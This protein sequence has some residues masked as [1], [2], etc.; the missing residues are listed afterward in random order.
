MQWT[1]TDP[2]PVPVHSEW[3][4]YLMMAPA[5]SLLILRIRLWG[6]SMKHKQRLEKPLLEKTGSLPFW[7]EVAILGSCRPLFCLLS[8]WTCSNDFVKLNCVSTT[9]WC[10][11]LFRCVR[12]FSNSDCWRLHDTFELENVFS[13][14]LT[15][16]KR[17]EFTG[18][19]INSS[20]KRD[21][22]I[23]VLNEQGNLF[24]LGTKSDSEDP[25]SELTKKKTTWGERKWTLWL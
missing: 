12:M 13:D 24:F 3:L 11:L 2:V 16:P 18:G 6:I 8:R 9:N 20:S 19:I 21:F 25:S 23:W 7:F 15:P 1:H 10:K 22:V 14:M 17:T 4:P 5:G